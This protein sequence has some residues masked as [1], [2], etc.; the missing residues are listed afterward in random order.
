MST[1]DRRVDAYISRS[2]AFARPILAHLREVVHAASPQI[3]E[4]IKWSMPWFSYRG[5][6]I[7]YM[8][9]FKAHAAF[10]FYGGARVLGAAGENREAMGSFGRLATVRDLPGKRRLTSLVRAALEIADEHLRSGVPRRTVKPEAAV[11]PPLARAL[12]SD[13]ALQARWKAFTP[14][15]RRSYVE[16]ISGAKQEVTRARR[17]AMALAWIS[18]GKSRDW[19]Q[20]MPH[21]RGVR[22][23]AEASAAPLPR[24]KAAP[25]R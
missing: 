17:L 3:D 12:K 25:G 2:A 14:G 11:P 23:A 13:S 18:E 7:C 8:A 24:R 16:W 6:P 19:K 15:M 22:R 9:A 5:R 4:S 10:G 21:R 20:E 1:R